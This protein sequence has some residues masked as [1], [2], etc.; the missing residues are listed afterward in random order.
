MAAADSPFY[1]ASIGKPS[2]RYGSRN[3]A[4][5]KYSLVSFMKS[6]S[7][8]AGLIGRHT[9]HSV[10]RTMISTLRKENVEALNIIALLDK[11]TLI[12]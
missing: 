12:I 9:N 1:L 6:M 2:S 11:E 8:V 7:E 4:W 5:E 10:R 3:S